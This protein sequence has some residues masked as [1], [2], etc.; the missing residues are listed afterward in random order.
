[1]LAFLGIPEITV[2][3]AVAVMLRIAGT[4]AKEVDFRPEIHMRDVDVRKAINFFFATILGLIASIML[5]ALSFS[6][7]Q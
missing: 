2:I 1:M 7:L 3:L 4:V 5:M 6:W